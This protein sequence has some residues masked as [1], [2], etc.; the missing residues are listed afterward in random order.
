[1]TD[2]AA[3]TLAEATFRE[4]HADIINCELPP[5]DWLRFDALRQRYGV[6]VSPL[7]EALSRL[8]SMGFVTSVG[9]RGF[10]VA[11]VSADDLVDLTKARI[12]AEVSALRSAICVGDR[13]WEA[14]ILASAHRLGDR[15]N[16]RKSG[17]SYVLDEDWETDH[18]EFHTALVAACPIK[19]LMAYRI[20]LFDESNRYRRLAVNRNPPNRDVSAEH[21]ALVDAALA[22]DL[23][24]ASILMENHLL[25]TTRRAIE[26]IGGDAGVEDRMALIKKD[27]KTVRG[28]MS[29]AKSKPGR[30]GHACL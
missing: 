19:R 10:R 1:M 6:S 24:R 3:K 27:L 17:K 20:Q 26:G 7:R 28:E 5:G 2:V 25:A 11:E 22:R 23:D 21:K 13:N 30:R 16:F 9:Q 18:R 4:I 14:N 15:P 8:T 29:S 12:W